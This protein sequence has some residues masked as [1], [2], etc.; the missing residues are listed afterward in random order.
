MD[1]ENW[2]DPGTILRGDY[3]VIAGKHQDWSAIALADEKDGRV[4]S[5]NENGITCYRAVSSVVDR[6]EGR[7]YAAGA[8][9]M[10]GMRI[11]TLQ[12]VAEKTV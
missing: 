3:L 11:P 10:G 6:W 2:T 7:G 5:R 12:T 8:V 1:R 9:A 4:Y